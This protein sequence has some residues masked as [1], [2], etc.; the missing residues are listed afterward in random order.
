MFL[1]TE[2]LI[3]RCIRSTEVEEPELSFLSL[4]LPVV[5]SACPSPAS[6]E[7]GV[8]TQVIRDYIPTVRA[9]SVSYMSVETHI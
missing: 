4:K 1:E 9:C 5:S 3:A 6:S 8:Y 2:K 7:G